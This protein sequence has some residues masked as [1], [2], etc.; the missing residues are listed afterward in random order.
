MHKHL[1][2]S[3]CRAVAQRTSKM[4]IY[5]PATLALSLF[6]TTTCNLSLAQEVSLASTAPSSEAQSEAAACRQAERET[7]QATTEIAQ[8]TSGV[9]DSRNLAGEVDVE[10]KS[11]KGGFLSALG[12][13][14]LAP[15]GTYI[16]DDGS[17][18]NIP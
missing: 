8:S 6:L 2:A 12:K 14:F 16:V 1:K 3:K 15:E 18:W 17:I 4:R 7:E 5:K 10:K 13:L 11:E 9:V